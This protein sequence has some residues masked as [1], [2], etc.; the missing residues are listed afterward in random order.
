MKTAEIEMKWYHF[1]PHIFILTI[2]PLIVHLNVMPLTGAYFDFWNGDKNNL[3]FFSYYKGIWLLVFTGLLVIMFLVRLFQSDPNLIKKDLRIYYIPAGVYLLFVI[4]STVFSKYQ[5]ISISGFPDRYEGIYILAAYIFLFFFTT[6]FTSKEK[7]VKIILGSLIIGATIIGSIGLFQYIGYDLWK[8]DFGKSLMIPSKYLKISNDIRFQFDKH[9]IYATLYHTD[10]VGSYMAMLFP[11]SFA[12]LV[13]VKNKWF[14]VGMAI[15]TV[16]MAINWL[17]CNSRAGFVG[18]VLALIVFLI[19]INKV[20]TRHWK[21]FAVGLM[22][23]I[24]MFLGLNQISHGY[25]NTRVASIFRDVKSLISSNGNSNSQSYKDSIPLKDIKI[26]GTKGTVVTAT[27]TL[28]FKLINNQLTFEDTNNKPIESSYDT[29]NGKITLKDPA[30]KDY[31]LL[32]GKDGNQ[33]VFKLDK[34]DIKLLFDL[35]PQGISLMDNKGKIFTLEPVESWGFN[36]KEKLGS[37]RGYIWSR[38]IPLLKNTILLG[39]G[40]DTFAAYFPQHDILG[41]MYAYNGDMWQLVDKPHDLYLQVALNT[42]MV[43]LLALLVLFGLYLFKSIKIYTKNEYD[44]FLSQVG[45]GVF[46]AIVGYLGAAFFNDS[47]VSVAPVF[48]IL[49]GL[50]V[51]INHIISNQNASKGTNFQNRKLGNPGNPAKIK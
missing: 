36:G 33:Y 49:L 15:I 38:S 41:K 11:L 40:P 32:A 26:S 10:Y 44:N 13:L 50:G 43:S 7:H 47:V 2:V 30:Y 37:S 16:I 34:G 51:S 45:V 18:G 22:V 46:I 20:L 23:T 27:E 9:T 42:G 21:Y 12:L 24:A 17:G 19:S 3:D 8:S 14:K 48:W 39:Y 1:L 25:V 5:N 6:A 29:S 4:V 28:N 35:K 31:S